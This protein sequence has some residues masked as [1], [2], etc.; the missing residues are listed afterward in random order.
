[1]KLERLKQRLAVALMAGI[2]AVFS[3]TVYAATGKDDTL[4]DL[5]AL[6]AESLD[7]PG[8]L[9]EISLYAN[10]TIAEEDTELWERFFGQVMVRNTVLPTLIPGFPDADKRNGKTI[11]IVPGGGY[12][13]VSIENEGFGIARQLQNAGYTTFIL[14]YRLPHTPEDPQQN[15]VALAKLFSSLGEKKLADHQPAVDDLAA[16]LKLVSSRSAE[17]GVDPR[18]IGVIG[19]SAGARTVIRLLENHS[20][21]SLAQHVALIYPPMSHTVKNG[22]RPPLFLTIAADDPLFSQ[23]GMALPQ[24]WYRQ[25]RNIEF[26]LF[27]SGGHGFGSRPSGST[28]DIW[29]ANYLSWL[30][31]HKAM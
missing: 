21:A 12:Q 18:Q 7:K 13:F 23:G 26:H 16:A 29:M 22:P 20:E 25:S 3:Y 31:H 6:Q 27:S 5:T 24:A 14:K 2:L 1:M 28:S 30:E 4:F 11:I 19:F 10:N 8:G 15:I 9:Q 17:W